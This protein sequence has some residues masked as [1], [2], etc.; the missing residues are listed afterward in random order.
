LAF[1]LAAY[2][3]DEFP[4]VGATYRV[5]FAGPQGPVQAGTYI[6]VARGS[7]LWCLTNRREWIN[8]DK[9]FSAQELAMSN[10]R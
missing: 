6:I 10:K 3:Q 7:G 1:A 9:F 5:S 4:K 8:F 2:S